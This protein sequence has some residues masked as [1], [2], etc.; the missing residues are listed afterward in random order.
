MPKRYTTLECEEKTADLLRVFCKLKKQKVKDVL[1]AII[2][3]N[4]EIQRFKE[5]LKTYVF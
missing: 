2:L 4:P 5:E 1:P 3:N